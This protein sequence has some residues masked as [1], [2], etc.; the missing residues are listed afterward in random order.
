MR[1]QVDS[2]RFE[3]RFSHITKSRWYALQTSCRFKHKR[4]RGNDC[5]AKVTE[6]FTMRQLLLIIYGCVL[7]IVSI[8]TPCTVANNM[9]LL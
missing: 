8:T 9:A 7:L 3:L 2:L 6:E 1:Q 5:K 4:G